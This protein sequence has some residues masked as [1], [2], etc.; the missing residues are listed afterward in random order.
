MAAAATST[1]S[2]VDTV[3]GSYSLL[4]VDYFSVDVVS[5]NDTT[6][7]AAIGG[8]LMVNKGA[9]GDPMDINASLDATPVT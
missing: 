7:S 9:L 5:Y 4:T 2:V 6:R 3:S 8:N 1:D